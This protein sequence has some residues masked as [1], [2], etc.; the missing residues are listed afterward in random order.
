MAVII[1][2][3]KNENVKR[4]KALSNRKGRVEQGLHFIEG[5]NLIR[6]AVVS[7]MTISDAF[8]EEGHD[9]MRAVL[10]GSGANVYVV[11]RAVMESLTH[12]ETPQWVCAC[13]K[14]PESALPDYYPEGL[15]VALDTVQDP[16]NL[17]TIIRTADAMGASGV[18]LSHGCADPFAPKTLRAAMGST[19]HLPLFSAGSLPEELERLRAQGFVTI[20]GHLKGAGELPD[21][22]RRCVLVIGNEGHGVS[23]EAAEKCVKYRLPMY[24]F[25]ESLNA[26]VAAGIMIYE[27][28][29]TMWAEN[30]E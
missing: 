12:T 3:T 30:K 9:I 24:G 16:G 1:E 8:I 27:L 19:Y 21:P 10:E 20:C 22:G 6:E 14:T 5:E 28:A 7:G 23:D 4:A 2:S 13:V 26:S 25:A 15:I 17:G 29:K 11:K 18:L